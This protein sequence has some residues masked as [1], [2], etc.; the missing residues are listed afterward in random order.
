MIAKEYWTLDEALPIIRSLQP[1]TRKFGYH[2]TLG[3]GVLNTGESKKDLDLF[4]LPL[5]HGGGKPQ[6]GWSKEP[7]P[8][9]LMEWLDSMWGTHEPLITKS[10]GY[11]DPPYYGYRENGND[12]EGNPQLGNF[13]ENIVRAPQLQ[14]RPQVPGQ[15]AAADLNQWYPL[16]D[17]LRW[18]NDNNVV[19]NYYTDYV[20]GGKSKVE[21]KEDKKPKA[22]VESYKATGKY[23][24]G[25]LRID[26][27]VF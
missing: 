11:G 9:K 2:L 19:Q 14:F 15:R 8:E 20:P 4:F 6:Q 1:H 7:L 27:F 26:V 13:W 10:Q 16:R 12:G 24:F 23:D 18:A 21:A 17:W 5:N 3:G 25:G 22:P